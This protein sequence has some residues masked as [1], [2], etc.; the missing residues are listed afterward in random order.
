MC[1]SARRARARACSS[2]SRNSALFGRPVQESLGG[3]AGTGARQ[4]MHHNEGMMIAEIEVTDCSGFP[5]QVDCILFADTKPIGCQRASM[6]VRKHA[7]CSGIR[8]RHVQRQ[9]KSPGAP[10]AQVSKTEAPRSFRD[11]LGCML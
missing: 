7:S 8:R 4:L 5:Q 3:A 10:D 2:R 6:T 9:L 11:W 1:S